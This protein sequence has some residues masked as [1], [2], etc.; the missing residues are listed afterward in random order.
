MLSLL[1]EVLLQTFSGR[2]ES[3]ENLTCHNLLHRDNLQVQLLFRIFYLGALPD[4]NKTI[5]NKNKNR[6]C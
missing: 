5:K 6:R 1:A 3:T 4:V 2:T